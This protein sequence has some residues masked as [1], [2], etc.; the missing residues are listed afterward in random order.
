VIR[1][2]QL[3]KY[4]RKDGGIETHVKT[5]CKNLV[6]A[7][8]NLVNLVSSIDQQGNWFEVD[9]YTVVESPTLGIYF[10]VS[11]APRMVFDAR[12]LH[13]QNAF[14]IIHLHFPDPMSHLVSMSLPADIPRVITWHSD[15][16]KQRRLLKIY[17]PFQ[18]RQIMQA[19]AIIAATKSHFTSSTQIPKRYPATRKYVIPYGMDLD[20]LELTTAL[21]TKVKNIKIQAGGKFMIFTIGRHVE[22]KGFDVLIKAMQQ[23]NAY[24]VLGGDGPLTP[25]LK[26]L[27]QEL[28]VID[29]V[30]FTGRLMGTELAAHYHACDVFCLPS[31]TRNEAFGIVQLEAMACGKPVICTQLHNGVNEINPHMTTGLTV[32][33]SNPN[34]LAEAI[35]QLDNNHPLRLSL[36]RN[37]R[38]HALEKF[39]I[40]YMVDQHLTM[41]TQVLRSGLN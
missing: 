29:R 11:M 16:I 35:N 39:S 6:S 5:L 23:T 33:A 7:G 32:L 27:A 30:R 34:A 20:W 24:L 3:G 38:Q 4:W 25:S 40:Q 1:V 9:G 19:D 8:V 2:L 12:R 26:T 18:L 41:Y 21:T 17:K 36:G 28:G 37:A 10:G 13:I 31:V 14:D 15:I 22:Y